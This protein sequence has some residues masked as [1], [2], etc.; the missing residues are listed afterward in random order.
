M[1]EIYKNFMFSKDLRKLYPWVSAVI[2]DDIETFLIEYDPNQSNDEVIVNPIEIAIAYESDNVFNHLVFDEDFSHYQNYTGLSLLTICLVFEKEHY[3]STILDR[4]DYT[5]EEKMLMFSHII[6]TKD[7]EYFKTFYG[8]YPI[9]ARFHKEFLMMSMANQEIFDYLLTLEQYKPIV[10][11]NSVIYQIL[12]HYPRHYHYIE[13][14]DDLRLFLDTDVFDQICDFMRFEDFVMAVDFLLARHWEIN[15]YNG[16]GLALI[17]VALRNARNASYVEYMIERGA[18]VQ[19]STTLDYAS[20]HQL[21]MRDASFTFEV[22]HLLDFNAQDSEGLT[23]QDYDAM[24]RT[25]GFKIEDAI[26]TVKCALNMEE[27]D[28]YELD[29]DEFIDFAHLLNIEMFNPY[30][31]VLMFDNERLKEEFIDH[32]MH[33]MSLSYF[34]VDAFNDEMDALPYDASKD[35]F[36]NT[37]FPLPEETLENIQVFAQN[38]GSKLIVETEGYEINKTA[39]YRL[40]VYSNGKLNEKMSIHSNLIDVF[41]AHHYLKVAVKD[42]IYAP[43]LSKKQRFLS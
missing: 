43:I 38:T 28:F 11:E 24:Q 39:Q 23:L 3:L 20:A 1:Y 17:H 40:E 27:E 26:R 31:V 7:M 6:D 9:H 2:N 25:E 14:M 19:L 18:N 5:E 42:I 4:F 29:I 21:L 41:F 34:D 35:L 33:E 30:L 13:D 12:G 8:Q 10:F 36:L 37:M 16:F 15:D 32:N 22:S